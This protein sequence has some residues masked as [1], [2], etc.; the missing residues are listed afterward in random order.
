MENSGVE[1]KSQWRP[2][3]A[4]DRRV[5]GVLA[6]KAKTTPD[7]YPMTLN[8]LVVGCNQKTNRHPVMNLSPT[9]VEDSLV[10]LRKVGAAAEVHGSGRVLK[11]QHYL[12]EWLGVTRVELAVMTEL[13]LRG[14]QTEG[15]LRSRVAR[16]EPVDDLSA[17]RVVLDSLRGKNLVTSLTPEGRGHVVSHTLY[18]PREFEHVRAEF[19]EA[20]VSAAALARESMVAT[21]TPER[22]PSEVG[23][24]LG[25]G[26]AFAEI[27][28]IR[29]ELQALTARYERTAEELQQLKSALGV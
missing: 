11:Y 27:E 3:P 24:G 21:R 20:P 17:L 8:G 29:A 4:I 2:I 7:V 26:D 10:R 19:A 9:D 18:E 12:Y 28:Q 14:A 5:V 1:T 15:E 6:E 16:M 25:S 23:S 13:L 22:P